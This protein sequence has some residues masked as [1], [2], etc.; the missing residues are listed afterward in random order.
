MPPEQ[1]KTP[2]QVKEDFAKRGET[3]TD[4]AKKH[5]YTREE[6]YRVLNGQ[7]KARYGKGHEIA[8]KLGLKT[9][10]VT[11]VRAA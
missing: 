3:I 2:E 11:P 10:G 1:V 9:I 4:W 7:N 6:V 8:K 5:G